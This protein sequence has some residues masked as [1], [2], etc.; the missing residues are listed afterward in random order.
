MGVR[1]AR[2]AQVSLCDDGVPARR[3]HMPGDK[4]VLRSVADGQTFQGGCKLCRIGVFAIFLLAA[5]EQR[6]AQRA[7]VGMRGDHEAAQQIVIARVGRAR[8]GQIVPRHRVIGAFA[9]EP[10]VAAAQ[11][12][13]VALGK[14]LLG[15]CA[16]CLVVPIEQPGRLC[17]IRQ[18][19]VRACVRD[20]YTCDR[21]DEERQRP[22]QCQ[23]VIAPPALTQRRLEAGRILSVPFAQH[24][25][26][27]MWQFMIATE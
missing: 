9:T 15:P 22:E 4:Q 11:F 16:E 10:S 19:R 23:Y 12:G 1:A 5:G 25:F 26:I 7:K 20:A 3:R 27:E 8:D 6:R 13:S 18:R 14:A 2:K 21:A 24:K 17:A